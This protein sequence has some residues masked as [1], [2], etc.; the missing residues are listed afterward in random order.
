L[1][2]IERCV[3]LVTNRLG[4]SRCP[5]PTDGGNLCAEHRWERD[6]VYRK[7]VA[8]AHP[9]GV[10][11]VTELLGIPRSAVNLLVE[12]GLLEIQLGGI[13][14]TSLRRL[15]TGRLGIDLPWWI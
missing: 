14:R 8:A 4:V 3:E 2:H 5:R 7:L 12:A 9:V 10:R 11:Q 6:Q 1:E 13:R 15:V